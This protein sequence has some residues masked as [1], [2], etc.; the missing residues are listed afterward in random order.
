M[1]RVSDRFIE[2]GSVEWDVYGGYAGS[3]GDVAYSGLMYY[4]IYPGA[5]MSVANTKYNYGE[6]VASATSKWLNVKC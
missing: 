1:S 4:Y 3:A 5:E 2:N 6:A